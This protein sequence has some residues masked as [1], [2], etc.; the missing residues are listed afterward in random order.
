ASFVTPDGRVN[1][2]GSASTFFYAGDVASG[3]ARPV[4]IRFERYIIAGSV[5]DEAGAPVDGAALAIGQAT[6]F[7]DSRGRFFVRLSDRRAVP[8]RVLLDEFLAAGAFEVV[9][10][11]TSATPRVERDHAPIRVVVRR[12]TPRPDSSGA[13]AAASTRPPND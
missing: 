11:P 13:A 4:E 5:V 12:A 7:T 2:T 10:A 6:V 3:A 1:Y 8:V 9:S